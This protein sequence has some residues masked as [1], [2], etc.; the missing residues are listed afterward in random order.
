MN[1][2]TPE[3]LLHM[4]CYTYDNLGSIREAVDSE[5]NAQ[6]LFDA[7]YLAGLIVQKADDLEPE[8]M[9]GTGVSLKELYEI[10][11]Q[12]SLYISSVRDM[13]IGGEITEA[14]QILKNT[15]EYVR[16]KMRVYEMRQ[17]EVSE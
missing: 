9:E 17:K 13:I 14:I 10:A 3:S 6:A 15:Q 5:D 2:V 12:I 11:M 1:K 8:D 4:G 7:G 16:E